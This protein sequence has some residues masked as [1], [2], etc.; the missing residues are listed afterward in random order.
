M[1]EKHAH[2]G[3]TLWTDIHG[4]WD[5]LNGNGRLTADGMSDDGS[6]VDEP[7]G[8]K[9]VRVLRRP[10]INKAIPELMHAVDTYEQAFL[11]ELGYEHQGNTSFKRREPSNSDD[12]RPYMVGLPRNFYDGDWYRNL[13]EIDKAII[14][15]SDTVVAIPTLVRRSI[16]LFLSF[17]S[18]MFE[19]VE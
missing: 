12:K 3:S 1:K 13:D 5:K 11:D 10:W 6:E 4:I 14:D 16:A 15:A 7:T 19:F 8:Q 18:L 2:S 9:F 17:R